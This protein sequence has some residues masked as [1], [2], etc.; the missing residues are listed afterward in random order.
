MLIARINRLAVSVLGG[1]ITIG[2]YPYALKSSCDASLGKLIEPFTWPAAV[3]AGVLTIVAILVLWRFHWSIVVWG[4][5]TA[6]GLIFWLTSVVVLLLVGLPGQE[7]Y[8]R[9]MTDALTRAA[10]FSALIGTIFL[11]IILRLET[12]FRARR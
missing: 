11:C 1:A 2:V 12:Q 7:V 10:F 4:S 5:S 6:V 8:Q 3:Y 9:E